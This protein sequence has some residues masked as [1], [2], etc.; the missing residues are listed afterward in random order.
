MSRGF[1]AS[2]IMHV[3][4]FFVIYFGLPNFRSKNITEDQVV[5]VDILPVSE[6]TNVKPKNAKPKS[7][8]KKEV[9][10]AAEP[11]KS[12][13]DPARKPEIKEA[14]LEPLPKPKIEEKPKEKPVKLEPKPK[15]IVK[16]VEQKK[17]EPKKEEKKKEEVPE[18][19]FAA[20]L[21][22]VEE[23]KVE[24]KKND[25]K[26]VDFS[27]V[28]DF[29]SNT[30]NEQQYKPGLPLTVSEK[31]AIRQQVMRNW[32]VLSGGKDAKDMAVMLDLK[33]APDGAVTDIKIRDMMRYNSD[34]FFRAMADS[35]IRA[36]KKSSPIKNLPP[37]K[38]DVKDGWREMEM[39][40]DPSEMMY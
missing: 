1:K 28:E 16:P 6:L 9:T 5:T 8:P 39:N 35:A 13:P 40:F 38:Y 17:P 24:D 33:L 14:E 4:M 11:K 12:L 31:D 15:E 7:E 3:I 29:L 36:V 23:M 18:D 32:T 25:S 2:V 19:A 26:D 30:A 20:V 22:S 27:E 34:S 10:A 21:K 37:E